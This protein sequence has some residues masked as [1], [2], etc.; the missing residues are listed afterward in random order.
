MFGEHSRRR[1][2]ATGFV[3]P[4]AATGKTFAIFAIMSPYFAALRSSGHTM[5]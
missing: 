5:R 3:A 4:W 1:T 2:G